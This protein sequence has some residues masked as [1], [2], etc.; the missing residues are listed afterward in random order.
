MMMPW[1][2]FLTTTTTTK[3]AAVDVERSVDI[4]IE[5][6]L[7]KSVVIFSLKR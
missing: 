4:A 7:N 5:T 3:M 2:H 6:V 1:R